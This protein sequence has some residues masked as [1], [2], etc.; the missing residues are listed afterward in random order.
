MSTIIFT[1]SL[2]YYKTFFLPPPTPFNF[3]RR[4]FDQKRTK[5]NINNAIV[6]NHKDFKKDLTPNV[7]PYFTLDLTITF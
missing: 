1:I 3:F 4:Y 5:I 2:E 7:G 6:V